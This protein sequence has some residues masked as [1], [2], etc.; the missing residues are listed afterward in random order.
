MNSEKPHKKRIMHIDMDA[1]FASIEQRDLPSL[2][3]KPVIVGG[4]P[5]KR[6]VVA[7]CSYEA[8]TFGVH[9]G[10]PISEAV[11]KCPHAVFLRTYGKKY[12]H[13]ARLLI[14][15][16]QR[17]SPVVEP[18]S[19]DEAYLDISGCSKL[20]GDE[21]STALRL[22]EN[23]KENLNLSC[24]IGIAP[25]KTFAKLAS[26]LQKPDGLTIIK[27]NEIEEKVYQLPVSKLWGIGEKTEKVLNELQIKTI[28]DLAHKPVKILKYRFGI[29]GEIL[30]KMARG[31]K[32]R[33]VM[34]MNE[35]RE[36]KSVGN[37]HTF[38][39]D[40]NNV[41]YIHSELLR[42]SQKVGRRL[43]EKGYGA[44]IITLK[45]RFEGF[46]TT[47]HRMTLSQ[48]I[49]KDSDIYRY[50]TTLFHEKYGGDKKIRLVGISLS[51]LS[52]ITGS[53]GKQYTQEEL[54]PVKTSE[55]S[56]YVMLDSLKDKFGE[57][58]IRRCNDPEIYYH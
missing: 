20:F 29:Y 57:K 39:R 18:V 31:E 36:E 3:N 58:I 45:I 7:T 16:F 5:G 56:L 2:G 42:L 15:I 38:Y 13:T 54:F 48:F 24:S 43:R 34:P 44:K 23:I 6:G 37:E 17:Y 46:I 10:M 30:Q 1:F 52:E 53:E 27:E 8:R 21:E 51:C 25:N 32:F 40:T 33:E 35:G 55:N 11:K 4:T 41:R 14:G 47:S 50:A 9:S 28:G 22:K 12:V 49:Y 26:A 19:I